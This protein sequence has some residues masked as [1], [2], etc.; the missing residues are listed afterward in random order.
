VND[1]RYIV[2]DGWEKFEH[3]GDR[4]TAPWIKNYTGLLKRDEY[5]DLTLA[6]RGVLHG[7]WLVYAMESGEITDRPGDLSRALGARITK[8][9]LEA[10]NHAGF[11]SFRASAE[12]DEEEEASA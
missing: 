9:T 1:R 4:R 12:V 5:L 8:A 3:Y 7:L 11:I 2:V 10:L 6:Q